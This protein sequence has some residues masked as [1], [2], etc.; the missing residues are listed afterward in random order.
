M[1][2]LSI[3]FLSFS[4][5]PFTA[6][7]DQITLDQIVAMV[8]SKNPVVLQA[9]E[10]TKAFQ[11]TVKESK[12]RLWPIFSAGAGYSAEGIENNGKALFVEFEQPLYSGG[13]LKNSIKRD[14]SLAESAHA[15]QAATVNDVALGALISAIELLKAK[16]FVEIRMGVEKIRSDIANIVTARFQAGQGA[17]R[18]DVEQARTALLDAQNDIEKAKAL[19]DEMCF[20]L[21]GFLNETDTKYCDVKDPGEPS[22]P[23]PNVDELL[24]IAQA[25]RPELV[26]A[27]KEV[28]ANEYDLSVQK[29]DYRPQFNLTAAWGYTNKSLQLNGPFFNESR[30]GMNRDWRVGV[31]VKVPLFNK[32]R[33]GR[34]E[35]AAAEINRAKFKVQ[36]VGAAVQR[37]VRT[38]SRNTTASLTTLKI[39][40]EGSSSSNIA[41]SAGMAEFQSGARD[42]TSLLI[43]SSDVANAGAK[44][45]EAYYSAWA[46]IFRLRRSTGEM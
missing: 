8:N 9:V 34:K 40:R 1:Q 22:T 4:I 16:R 28:S 20:Q 41:Y 37:E 27:A 43:L 30:P 26:A 6:F 31:E 10:N 25:K 13:R 17:T 44:E 3:V 21:L 36:E 39:T 32:S 14:S 5:V 2:R 42:L 33:G 15:L 45:A 18:V 19:A 23:N 38:D 35:R 29:A 7:G 11:A 12:G 46:N 24:R